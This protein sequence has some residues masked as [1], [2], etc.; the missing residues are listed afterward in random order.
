MIQV[1]IQDLRAATT[2]RVARR[3]ALEEGWIN[4][5]HLIIPIIEEPVKI[6]RFKAAFLTPYRQ[7]IPIWRLFEADALGV[8][9]ALEVAGLI[10][11]TE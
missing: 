11:F 4:A 3:L 2:E 10:Q 8:V 1:T 5:D 7:P 9:T 6:G